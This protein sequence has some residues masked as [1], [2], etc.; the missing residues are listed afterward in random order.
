MCNVYIDCLRVMQK[1]TNTSVKPSLTTTRDTTQ[2]EQDT[3][4]TT[5]AITESEVSSTDSGMYFG[6]STIY[7]LYI[8]THMY[9]LCSQ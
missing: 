2:S 6:N 9:L 7:I 5:P 8:H 1:K 3:V 4:V